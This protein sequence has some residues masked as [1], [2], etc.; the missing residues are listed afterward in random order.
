MPRHLMNVAAV[1]LLCVCSSA[2]YARERADCDR[3]YQPKFGQPG[4][5]VAWE[6]TIEPIVDAMLKIANTTP[7]D[8]VIDLGAGDGAIVIGAA[9]RFGARGIGIEYNPDLARLAQCYIEVEGL[10]GKAQVIRGDIFEYDFSK[11]TVLTLYLYPE[12]NVRVRPLILD[13]R[14]GTRVVSHRHPMGDWK[15]DKKTDVDGDD[16][17]FWIVPAKVQGKWTLSER[18]GGS[19]LTMALDQKF[20]ELSGN[21]QISGKQYGLQ[22]QLRG[23]EIT[24]GFRD[25]NNLERKLTGKVDNGR[26]T[27]SEGQRQYQAT[28]LVP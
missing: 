19:T 14:P 3:A 4:K 6:P 28:R 25:E 21:V 5:D 26:M 1:V 2:V 20:Q 7:R 11:A 24:L 23:A 17:Y 9:K 15:P 13:M 16:V 10:T 22:G 12:L 8:L 18:S 27:L